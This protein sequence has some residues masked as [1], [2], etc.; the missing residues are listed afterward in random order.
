[1]SNS[2]DQ[3]RRK[4]K[5]ENSLHRSDEDS[6]QQVQA[7]RNRDR[8][9]TENDQA[10]P[11]MTNAS[12]LSASVFS[13]S[14]SIKLEWQSISYNSSTRGMNIKSLIESWQQR[15]NLQGSAKAQRPILSITS[16]AS[17]S[18]TSN[19]CEKQN[20][21]CN[22]GAEGWLAQSFLLNKDSGFVNCQFTDEASKRRGA[23]SKSKP[24]RTRVLALAAVPHQKSSPLISAQERTRS[25]VKVR[26]NPGQ[27]SD[28]RLTSHQKSTSHRTR[29]VRLEGYHW[30]SKEDNRFNM[31]SSSFIDDCHRSPDACALGCW[32]SLRPDDDDASCSLRASNFFRT[33]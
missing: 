9:A 17:G 12:H 4:S 2:G 16:R 21:K 11:N 27:T 10:T 6:K 31:S 8:N 26:E 25:D 3:R 24:E 23:S 13:R 22:V 20:D 7:D 14:R 18:N 30:M 32:D 29:S 5:L 1:M 28:D 15:A 19:T 33:W